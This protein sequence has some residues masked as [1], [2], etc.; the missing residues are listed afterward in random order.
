MTRKLE[1]ATA[2]LELDTSTCRVQ[3]LN[4][5][6]TTWILVLF[7]LINQDLCVCRL[8]LFETFSS[9][10]VHRVEVAYVGKVGLSL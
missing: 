1:N 6:C 2:N 5:A 3:A 7:P 9:Y 10:V 4:I 8:R